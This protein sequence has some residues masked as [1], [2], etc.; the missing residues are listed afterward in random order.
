[1]RWHEELTS[2]HFGRS[3]ETTFPPARSS[4][5][6]RLALLMK[7]DVKS[8]CKTGLRMSN[9]EL[10]QRSKVLGTCIG[11]GM[12]GMEDALCNWDKDTSHYTYFEG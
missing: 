7:S 3:C 5:S 6:L 12:Q 8:S 1:M 11:V 10:E 4:I 2:K 9:R